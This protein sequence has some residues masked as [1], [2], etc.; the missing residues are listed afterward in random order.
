MNSVV[1]HTRSSN[2]NQVKRSPPLR[3]A[4]RYWCAMATIDKMG[5]WWMTMMGFCMSTVCFTILATA[6]FSPL[7]TGAS[8]AGFVIIYG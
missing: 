4:R 3:T 6:Y 7:R 8:G 5:R 1:G 2:S